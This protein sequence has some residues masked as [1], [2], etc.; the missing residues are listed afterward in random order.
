MVSRLPHKISALVYAFHRQGAL[1]MLRRRHAPNAGL[2]SPFGGKLHAGDGESPH[3][4]AARETCEEIGLQFRPQDFHLT[5]L[6][7]E[8]AYEGNTH[9]LMF[10]FELQP[11]LEALPPPHDEGIFEFVAVEEVARREIPSTDREVLWPLFQKHRGGF[12]AISI[13]C[14][15]DGSLAW[16]LDQPALLTAR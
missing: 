7:A 2:W 10:M 6:V 9:W 3:Q 8:K 14:H 12:F 1:L 13:V 11:R 5:G 15:P 4:C 16:E